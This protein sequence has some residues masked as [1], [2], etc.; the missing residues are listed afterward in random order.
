MGD[1][2]GFCAIPVIKHVLGHT[3]QPKIKNKNEG[4][5]TVNTLREARKH[6]HSADVK[7]SL[8]QSYRSSE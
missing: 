2:R 7:G 5:S 4:G 8:R 1:S 3:I 6:Q